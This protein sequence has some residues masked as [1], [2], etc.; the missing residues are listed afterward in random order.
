MLAK[1]R[2]PFKIE[3]FNLSIGVKNFE[4]FPNARQDCHVGG[5]SVSD[6]F[7]LGLAVDPDVNR[8][9]IWCATGKD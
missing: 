6:N 3:N 5:I 7:A 4:E 9:G 8:I 1:W 2:G